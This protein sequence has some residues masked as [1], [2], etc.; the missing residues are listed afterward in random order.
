MPIL[1]TRQRIY[2]F[3]LQYKIANQGN[4][5]TYRDMVKAGLAKSVSTIS[6]HVHRLARDGQLSVRDRRI[7]VP[8]AE[9]TPPDR[10][11]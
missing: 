3:I 6:L 2:N 7:Y 11:D 10:A 9:W 8:D 5:P 1:S 4:G